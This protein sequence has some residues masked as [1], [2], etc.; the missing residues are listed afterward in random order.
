MSNYRVAA[1]I[2]WTSKCNARCIMCPRDKI[3]APRIMD[4]ALFQKVLTRLSSQDLFRVVIAGYGEPT[5]HPRFNEMIELL[6]GN[7]IQF[8]MVTNGQL[9]NQEKIAKIDGVIEN[10]IVSFSSINTKVYN[11]VHANLDQKIVLSNIILAN[12][13]LKKTKLIISLTPLSDCLE[14]LPDTIAWFRKNGINA[15][16]MSPSLYDRAGALDTKKESTTQILRKTIKDNKLHSQELDF[17]PS[18]GDVVKQWLANKVKCIPRNSDIL[19]SSTGYYMYCFND[20]SHRHPIASVLEIGLREALELR[21]KT[22]VDNTVCAQCN[23]KKR[24]RSNEVLKVGIK[25]LSENF[26]NRV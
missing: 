16:S 25:Y 19:I 20:I 26:K 9:L 24:Y 1:N 5:T 6:R 14:T 22:S 13:M 7:P 3:V 11:R 2:E 4:K 23:L 15:L 17:I 18:I 10:I 12:K 8:D 21:E